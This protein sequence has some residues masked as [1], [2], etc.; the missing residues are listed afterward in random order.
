[1]QSE[2]KLFVFGSFS[3]GMFHF[4]KIERFISRSEK[5]KIQASAHLLMS[6]VTVLSE[7]RDRV[8]GEVI[9][10]KESEAAFA[11]LDSWYGLHKEEALFA[12]ETVEVTFENGETSEA[13]AYFMRPSQIPPTA[14]HVRN[15]E[16]W[17]PVFH[18]E[19]SPL[20]RLTEREVE[21]LKKI[22]EAGRSRLNYNLDLCRALESTQLIED[23]GRRYSLSRLGEELVQFV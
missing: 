13:R 5:A 9:T 15:I 6:G 11:L 10:L 22:K 2:Q 21:Y 7:G 8:S 16:E 19:R 23:K 17:K 1:M 12:C 14:K 20:S 4:K 3:N 18:Q